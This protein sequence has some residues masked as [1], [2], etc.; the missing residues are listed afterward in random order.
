MA[1][2]TPNNLGNY[3]GFW[4]CS[5]PCT[6]WQRESFSCCRARVRGQVFMRY[7]LFWSLKPKALFL[8]RSAHFRLITKDL[9]RG[10]NPDL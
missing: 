7:P 2:N 10:N 4:I 3:N 9:T 1:R 5:P 8:L 6:F